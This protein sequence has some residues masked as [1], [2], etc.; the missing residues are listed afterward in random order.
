MYPV[1]T[2]N[3]PKHRVLSFKYAIEGLIL[4]LKEEPNLKFHAVTGTIAIFLGWFFQIEFS[5]WLVILVLIGL[6][7]SLELTNTA[8]EAIV[9]YLIP[10]IHP[11]AKKVK[12]IAAASVLVASITALV[13]GV[14]IFW[15][16]FNM[17]LK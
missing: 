6:V 17:F 7:I 12:D 16:Y 14:L 15:P 11:V 3:M 9:D 5:E 4:A 1:Y 2:E 8:L 10:Q 13:I